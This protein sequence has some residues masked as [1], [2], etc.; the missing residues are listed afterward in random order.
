M[1]SRPQKNE[2]NTKANNKKTQ[3]RLYDKNDWRVMNS[4]FPF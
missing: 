4:R 1:H 3:K 2:T